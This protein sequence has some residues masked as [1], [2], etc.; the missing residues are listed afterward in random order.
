VSDKIHRAEEVFDKSAPRGPVGRPGLF[1][2]L[3]YRRE[4]QK[5]LARLLRKQLEEATI[6]LWDYGDS[7]RRETEFRCEIDTKIR[8]SRAVII[9]LSRAWLESPE[10]QHEAKLAAELQRRRIWLLC[11]DSRPPED[12]DRADCFEFRLNHRKETLRQL[13]HIIFPSRRKKPKPA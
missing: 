8:E 3:S 13:P 5:N 9:L 2:M 1:V 6:T 10:C 7:P 12:V 4:K 11:D